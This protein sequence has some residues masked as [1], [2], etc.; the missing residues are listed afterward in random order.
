M[1]LKVIVFHLKIL[2]SSYFMEHAWCL[3]QADLD[4]TEINKLTA[5][6]IQTPLKSAR[7]E[8]FLKS[9]VEPRELQPRVVGWPLRETS[10]MESLPSKSLGL[11]NG[12]TGFW[13][14]HSGS[15]MQD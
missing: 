13:L 14:L 10:L 6:A 4:M 12:E 15:C 11:I 3:L 9:L 1:F 8:Y 2:F 7:S 5:E